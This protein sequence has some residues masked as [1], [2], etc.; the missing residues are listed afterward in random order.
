MN[1]A[2]R[3]NE[4]NIERSLLSAPKPAAGASKDWVALGAVTPVKNQGQCGSCWA[5]STTGSFEGA[6]QVA[7]GNLVSFSEQNLVSCDTV[8]D[9]CSGGLMDNAFGWIK[10][11]GGLCTEDDYPYTSGSGSSGSC[12]TS[13]SKAATLTGWSDVKQGDEDAL[14]SAVE[15]GPVS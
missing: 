2:L 4:L 12:K 14:K 10:S 6:Y 8:D 5:F 1:I 9:G 7:T 11:N 3:K 15:K 13:C